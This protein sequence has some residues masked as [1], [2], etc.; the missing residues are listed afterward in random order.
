MQFFTSN[1]LVFDKSS[2]HPSD[3][4]LFPIKSNH[5]PYQNLIVFNVRL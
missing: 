1:T 5:Y 2:V 4:I 3:G